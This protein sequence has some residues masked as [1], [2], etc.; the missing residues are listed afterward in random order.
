MLGLIGLHA[1][2]LISVYIL[3][4]R[5]DE[6]NL[7]NWGEQYD[8]NSKLEKLLRLRNPWGKI[9]W[10]HNWSDEDKRWDDVCNKTKEK[11]HFSKKNDGIF[12]M[13][14]EDF[15]EYFNHFEICYY[16]DFFKR[17]SCKLETKIGETKSLSFEINNKG[18]YYFSIHQVNSRFW[19]DEKDYNYSNCAQIIIRKLPELNEEGKVQYELVGDICKKGGDGYFEYDCLPGTYYASVFTP[20][21]SHS[22][23]ITLSTYGPAKVIIK[24]EEDYF[25]K[26]EWIEEAI[27]YNQVK[28]DQL[29]P[30]YK[31]EI[32]FKFEK[33]SAIGYIAFQ[34]ISTDVVMDL[35][36]SFN[37]SEIFLQGEHEGK[38]DASIQ[39][40]PGDMNVIWW[41]QYDEEFQISFGFEVKFSQTSEIITEDKKEVQETTKIEETKCCW[42]C[43]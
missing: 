8:P 33:S 5:N 10:K 7:Q 28:N 23:I 37:D 30:Y 4:W 26:N 20:W 6:W 34:N 31:N 15:E 43:K 14:F 39:S 38:S 35:K 13:N 25:I 11:I 12:Y 24:L 41:R 32:Y 1:Y 27:A 9:E 22:N 3:I 16:H 42:F 2:A 18:L 40:R 29:T 21:E 19:S 17:S 36:A